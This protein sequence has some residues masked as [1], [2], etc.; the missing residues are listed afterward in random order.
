MFKDD[1]KNSF[2]DISPKKSLK[3]KVKKDMFEKSVKMKGK[4]IFLNRKLVYSLSLVL[5]SL[6]L[7]KNYFPKNNDIDFSTS[8]IM[9]KQ[10]DARFDSAE[11]GI[12]GSY[13]PNMVTESLEDFELSEE[14]KNIEFYEVEANIGEFSLDLNFEEGS[15]EDMILTYEEYINYLGFEPLLNYLPEDFYLTEE[16]ES[17]RIFN[18]YYK[19]GKAAYDPLTISYMKNIGE[20]SPFINLTVS[21][22]DYLQS[23]NYSVDYIGKLKEETIN[24]TKVYLGYD[25]LLGNKFHSEEEIEELNRNDEYSLYL[26]RFEKDGVYYTLSTQYLNKEEFLKILKSIV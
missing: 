9:E 21:K 8:D 4:N 10:E 26:A 17:I 15:T 25:T 24:N 14:E 1:Y 12:L 16:L 11:Q 13:N 5:I 22:I 6:L 18:V 2:K 19:D 3:D 7:I 20:Q 23:V